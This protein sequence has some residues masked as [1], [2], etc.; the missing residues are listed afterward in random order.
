MSSYPNALCLKFSPPNKDIYIAAGNYE[1]MCKWRD[2]LMFHC[3]RHRNSKSFHHN[4]RLHNHHHHHHHHKHHKSNTESNNNISKKLH[5]SNKSISKKSK[6]TN[7][8]NKLNDVDDDEEDLVELNG[9]D[10]DDE[11]IN[12]DEE[13]NNANNDYY[14]EDDLLGDDEEDELVIEEKNVELSPTSQN[15][16][17]ESNENENTN[18]I[19][20]SNTNNTNSD[21]SRRLSYKEDDVIRK[22][23]LKE[24]LNQLLIEYKHEEEAQLKKYSKFASNSNINPPPSSNLKQQNRTS[25][26]SCY[27]INN[28]PTT[29]NKNSAF[30]LVQNNQSSSFR[31]ISL[32]NKAISGKAVTK[33]SG[34]SSSCSS[35]SPPKARSRESSTNTITNTSPSTQ[36]Q[37][38]STSTSTAELTISSHSQIYKKPCLISPRKSGQQANNNNNNSSNNQDDSP[39]YQLANSNSSLNV[40]NNNNNSMSSST[41]ST[42]STLSTSSNKS[43]TIQV[44]N[45][46]DDSTF[47]AD[48]NKK[49][50]DTTDNNSKNEFIDLTTKKNLLTTNCSNVSG[51]LLL[52]SK[53]NSEAFLLNEKYWFSLNTNSCNLL[54]WN[55]KYEQDLGKFPLGKYELSKCSQLIKD[56]QTTTINH[57]ENNISNDLAFKITFHQNSSYIILTAANK[58]NKLSWCE[59]IKH[60]IDNISSNCT[61]CKPKLVVN[62]MQSLNNNNNN[63]LNSPNNQPSQ[64]NDDQPLIIVNNAN[65]NNNS[66]KKCTKQVSKGM[67]SPISPSSRQAN[68]LMSSIQASKLKSLENNNL[69]NSEQTSSTSSL[70][71]SISYDSLKQKYDKLSI[72]NNEL[73]S[74]FK[75]LEQIHLNTINEYEKRQN[76]LY[77]QIDEMHVKL[78]NTEMDVEQ[79]NKKLSQSNKSNDSS[80]MQ[81]QNLND[82]LNKYKETMQLQ[83]KEIEKLN[84]KLQQINASENLNQ[85]NDIL[86]NCETKIN[87]ES[88]NNKL[89]GW[90]K[91]VKNLDSRINDLLAKIKERE[92][93]LAQISKVSTSTQTTTLI[94]DDDSYKSKCDQLEFQLQ[95]AKNK[96]SQLQSNN[97]NSR[98]SLTKPAI[99]LNDFSDDL[100]KV[101]M[102]KE[103]VITSLEK[104]LKD[105]EKQVQTLTSQLNEEIFQ[106]NKYQDAF[107]LELNR[108]TQLNNEIKALNECLNQQYCF[109]TELDSLKQDLSKSNSYIKQ[110]E[111]D[112]NQSNEQKEKIEVEF[113]NFQEDSKSELEILQEEIKTFEYKLV[114]SQRQAQEYQ[115][116]LEDMDLTN[117]NSINFLSQT[118]TLCG[119]S[120]SSLG[121]MN[122]SSLQNRLKR[123][124]SYVQLLIQQIIQIKNSNIEELSAKLQQLQNEFEEIK[125]ENID[126][127]DHIYSVDVYMREKEAQCDDYQKE[128][129]ELV[130]KL[131]DLTHRLAKLDPNCSETEKNQ[132]KNIDYDLFLDKLRQNLN[133]K[134]NNLNDF[135]RFIL[136]L[137]NYFLIKL[138]CSNATKTPNDDMII[139]ECGILEHVSQLNISTTCNIIDIN[140]FK[141]ILVDKLIFSNDMTTNLNDIKKSLKNLIK[142]I[143]SSGL[144]KFNNQILSYMAEQL[145]HKAAL[146]GHLKFACELLRKKSDQQDNNSNNPTLKSEQDE[147]IFKLASELLLSDE[148]S[149]RKLSAQL[150]NEA[151]HLNQL[152]CV[153]NSLNKLRFKN[154]SF[155][156]NKKMLGECLK[157]LDILDVDQQPDDADEELNKLIEDLN[158]EVYY[159]DPSCQDEKLQNTQLNYI[160]DVIKSI[161]LQHKEQI[162]EQLNEVHKLMS[163]SSDDDLLAHLQ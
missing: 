72:D 163:I 75:L 104:Q 122:D 84:K 142:F 59:S 120:P 146:N 162:S 95:E 7:R 4:H 101:L 13:F 41:S 5:S 45:S 28:N 134:T 70:S 152:N 39:A 81:L 42:S 24:N 40:P 106:S 65:N 3:T 73:Q 110:L 103:E 60:T 154:L 23:R 143:N 50:K 38:D 153:L 37:T 88:N 136:S 132:S 156:Q 68:S 87:P 61:K 139:S 109:N 34:S 91:E 127:N 128:K 6:S 29:A 31:P 112:I 49:F 150:L 108:N 77:N 126:L 158:N 107:N 121:P 129:D 17:N 11:E 157:N 21:E 69:G 15:K 124:Q 115:S 125:E 56:I 102:S 58:E 51:F 79:L 63:N 76:R 57:Y 105:R 160:L 96:I 71:S 32:P 64:I 46:V 78:S 62:P 113:K 135:I 54:Y 117:T 155:T 118:L 67:R 48:H 131:N 52:K 93:N 25:L 138:D 36:A 100:G 119:G 86:V 141:Q 18:N 111:Y 22:Q 99:N 47:I 130:E 16:T 147:K 83:E 159:Q 98:I 144:T 151:Q 30:S 10:L 14:E 116:I 90:N 148:D 161:F 140:T 12:L 9:E 66:S 35:S 133:S 26:D 27:K 149:L 94:C 44:R 97:N 2:V 145:I 82:H 137:C 19:N 1:E 123:T 80:L 53:D 114:H 55:D 74:K 89:K 33:S 85:I 92:M 8:H 20:N 43:L